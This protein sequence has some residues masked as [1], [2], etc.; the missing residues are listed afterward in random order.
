[1]VWLLLKTPQRSEP[2]GESAARSGS[3]FRP[4]AGTRSAHDSAID[5]VS[6]VGEGLANVGVH[7]GRLQVAE[8]GYEQLAGQFLLDRVTAVYTS[9]AAAELAEG[10]R[11]GFMLS[12][13]GEFRDSAGKTYERGVLFCPGV[14]AA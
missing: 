1:M 11:P 9:I 3:A 4:T 6:L 13:E 5:G 10:D 8:V 2:S 7:P 14:R 12:L